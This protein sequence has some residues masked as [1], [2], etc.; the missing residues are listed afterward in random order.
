MC[1]ICEFEMGNCVFSISTPFMVFGK[2]PCV[3]GGDF[4]KPPPSGV[5]MGGMGGLDAPPPLLFWTS[6]LI[7]SKLGRNVCV[8]VCGGGAK[9]VQRTS[10]DQVLIQ[11]ALRAKVT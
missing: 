6:F 8:A 10:S 9:R 11:Q 1:G 5:A 7:L 3:K 4:E 2:F